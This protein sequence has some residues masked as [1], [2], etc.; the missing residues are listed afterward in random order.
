MATLFFEDYAVGATWR[1]TQSYR[2]EEA[3]LLDFGRRWDPQPF[4]AD[5]VAARASAFGGLVAAGCHV[6]CIR[7]WLVHRLPDRPALLAGLGWL[8]PK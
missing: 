4:H 5:P 8:S 6:F 3:E 7:S 2:V 1:S